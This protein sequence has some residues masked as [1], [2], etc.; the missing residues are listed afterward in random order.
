MYR[1]RELCVN[2]Y[3]YIKSRQSRPGRPGVL[4][5]LSSVLTGS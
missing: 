3:V 5:L 1:S 4:D 2:L